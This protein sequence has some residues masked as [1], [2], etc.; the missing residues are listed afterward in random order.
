MVA[1]MGSRPR[2][3][4]LYGLSTPVYVGRDLRWPE[5]LALPDVERR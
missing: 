4:Q 5:W 2:L 1:A 3:W